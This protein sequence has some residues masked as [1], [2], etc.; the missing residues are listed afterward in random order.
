MT[1]EVE[2]MEDAE[3]QL[4]REQDYNLDVHPLAKGVRSAKAAIN[5]ILKDAD[6]LEKLR[7]ALQ[8]EFDK[9]PIKFLERF[10]PLLKM[11]EEA[12]DEVGDDSKASVRIFQETN[13]D[14]GRTAIEFKSE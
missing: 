7:L 14:S 5:K 13:E 9:N 3:D 4:P 1:G 12:G 11:Y 2:I 6:N 8:T 10:A